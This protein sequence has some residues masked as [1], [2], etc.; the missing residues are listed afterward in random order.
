[1]GGAL[2]F[3]AILVFYSYLDTSIPI[4]VLNIVTGRSLVVIGNANY[5]D[6]AA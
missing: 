1:M 4:V 5:L 3:G 2:R 6:A